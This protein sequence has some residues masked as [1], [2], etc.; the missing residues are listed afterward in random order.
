MKPQF[1]VSSFLVP[2]IIASAVAP[3]DSENDPATVCFTYFSTYL[4]PILSSVC[5]NTTTTSSVGTGI[6]ASTDLSGGAS[7][8]LSTSTGPAPPLQSSSSSLISASGLP[9]SSFTTST[10]G[11][12]TSTNTALSSS[13]PSALQPLIFLVIPGSTLKK[14]SLSKRIVGGFVAQNTNGDRQNC[15]SADVYN[16]AFG[17][18]LF[19]GVPVYY[20]GENYKL[21]NAGSTPP[22]NAITTTFSISGGILRFSN[23]VLPV[24]Q[25]SFCQD[26]NA[27]VYITFASRPPNCE[28]VA[29]I[30][31]TGKIDHKARISHVPSCRY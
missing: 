8:T 14:R 13:S 2:H 30:A 16:L 31:Y 17:R 20:S 10:P 23:P 5:P 26:N 7:Q 29:L 22:E 1:L 24:D 21:L 15:N 12:S 3:P 4:E 11:I 27:Q 6:K 9:S 19:N 28:P 18:L 25:A